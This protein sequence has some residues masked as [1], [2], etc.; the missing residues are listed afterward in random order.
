VGADIPE[1]E[2]SCIKGETDGDEEA[3]PEQALAEWVQRT[4]LAADREPLAL[5]GK[6]VREAAVVEPYGTQAA[7]HLLFIPMHANR[8]DCNHFKRG[9]AAG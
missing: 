2:T 9:G 5:G 4:Y 6:L 1:S 7:P 3:E 8:L